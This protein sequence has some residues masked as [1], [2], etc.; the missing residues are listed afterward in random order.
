MKRILLVT[1]SYPGHHGEATA[2]VFIPDFAQA[3]VGAGVAVDLVAPASADDEGDEDGIWVKRFTVPR[4]PLSLLNPMSLG[5]WAAIVSTLKRGLEMVTEVAARR[6]PD[7][8]LALWVLPSGD[9]AMRAG[10]RLGIPYSTWALGSDIWS[11]GHLPLVRQHLGRVLRHAKR[12]FADGYQLADDVAQISGCDCNFL[13]TSRC[14]GPAGDRMASAAPPYRMVFLG[15]WHPNKGIDLLLDALAMLNNDDWSRIETVKLYGGGPLDCA[16]LEGVA[17]LQRAGRP[18]EAGG[19]LDLRDAKALFEWGDFVLIPSRIESIPVVFSDAMQA[20]RPV[21]ATPVGDLPKLVVNGRNGW[22]A[23]DTTSIGLVD[24]LRS[25]LG[26]GRNWCISDRDTA[27][28][29]PS[30]VALRFLDKIGS[31]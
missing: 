23:T 4:L 27:L 13:P 17:R 2:G 25:V 19:Y 5:D 26:P 22:L 11:L 6:R 29:S 8:I 12:R 3:M 1:T 21:I 31:P 30:A 7:H 9:W 14:F 15:R 16:V 24:A 28:F 20:R 10:S 18:V